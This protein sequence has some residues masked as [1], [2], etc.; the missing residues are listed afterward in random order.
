MGSVLVWAMAALSVAVRAEGVV[1]RECL[2][3]RDNLKWAIPNPSL[4]ELGPQKQFFSWWH[5]VQQGCEVDSRE[6]HAGQLSA[7]CANASTDDRHGLRGHIELNQ[8][9]PAPIIV[10]AWSKARDVSRGPDPEYCLDVDV[11]FAD[12]TARTGPGLIHPFAPGTHDWQR[13]VV[14]LVPDRA[15]KE[16]YVRPILLNRIGTAWFDDIQLWSMDLPPETLYFDG[17]PIGPASQPPAVT[18][19]GPSLTTN[20]GL[21]LAFDG[22]TGHPRTTALGGFFLRDAEALSDFRQPR[23]AARLQDDGSVLFEAEDEEL[24]L[25]LSAT[26]RVLD[27]AIRIDGT[28]RDLAGGDRAIT[29]YFSYPIDGT[30]WTWHED[31]RA[32]RRIEARGTYGEFAQTLAGANGGSS[33]WPLACMSSDTDALVIGAALD[34]PRLYRFGY[35]ADTKELYAAVDLGL[36]KDTTNS[37][38]EATF[39]LVLYRCDPTWGFRS[40]LERYYALFPRCFVKRNEK[41]G[42]WVSA[43]DTES[44]EGSE[45][46]GIQFH[47]PNSNPRFHYER[48]ITNLVYT[49]PVDLHLYL[50]NEE[51]HTEERALAR[52]RELAAA[53]DPAGLAA[54]S[55]AVH[56][57]NGE[58]QSDLVTGPPKPE[59]FCYLNPCPYLAKAQPDVI[60]QAKRRFRAIDYAVRRAESPRHPAWRNTN[61][62][63]AQWQAGYWLADGEGRD[64]SVAACMARASGEEKVGA[65]Q[66]VVLDQVEPLPITARVWAKAENVSGDPDQMYALYV[67]CEYTDGK[68]GWGL[69]VVP[70]ATGTHDW[71]LLEKTVTPPKPIRDLSF[72]LVLCDPHTGKVWFDDA[73]L[74]EGDSDRD[75]LVGGDFGESGDA[76]TARLG[77]TFVD[78]FERFSLVNNYRREHWAATETPLAFDCSARVCQPLIFPTVGFVKEL[79]SWMHGDGRLVFANGTPIDYPWGIPYIDGYARE[80]CWQSDGRY[81]P[82]PDHVMSYRRAL[83]YQRPVFLFQK[84]ADE[85]YKAEWVEPFMKRCAAYGFLPAMHSDPPNDRYW[86]RP[87]LYNRDRHLWKKYVPVIKALSAAG[88]EPIT[89]ARSDNP[90][91]YVE[92]FGEPGGSLYLTLFNDSHERQTATI[93]LDTETLGLA[94]GD[95]EINEVLGGQTMTVADGQLRDLAVEPEDVKV[96]RLIE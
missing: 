60:T 27:D 33:R 52:I 92:R 77:G 15:I 51:E 86:E 6:K 17:I 43:V 91:V 11:H 69:V 21:V 66:Q 56:D 73:F 5:P 2:W 53:A 1:Y 85:S 34:V 26:Y 96:L 49:A 10:E 3:T 25:R 68:P 62:G 31:Q 39:S 89:Y 93:S 37:P 30:G 29:V 45:D 9:A 23:G 20:D 65:T 12:G 4:E 90:E 84:P 32:G 82:E 71:Q 7:R 87:D 70:A 55:S 41:E 83:A 19:P 13:G 72:H 58:W 64:G 94:A 76:V 35:C 18:M 59:Y 88:W 61:R 28:A 67:D 46:F 14:T 80:V 47:H 79:A 54:E 48:G 63:L 95:A 81:A 44:I 8:Q 42:I 57:L 38:S 75:L 24:R 78:T 16:V 74:G 50:G 22:G 36:S 40:A